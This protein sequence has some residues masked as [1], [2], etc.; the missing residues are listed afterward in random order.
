MTGAMNGLLMLIH[1]YKFDIEDLRKG[2]IISQPSGTH[3]DASYGLDVHDLV[4]MA[5][6]AEDEGYINTAARLLR[7]AHLMVK[8]GDTHLEQDEVKALTKHRKVI[9]AKHNGLL[10]KRKT[11]LSDKDVV[12]IHMLDENLV[13]KKKQP[14]YVTSGKSQKLDWNIMHNH[15]GMFSLM[16]RQLEGCRDFSM[17]KGVEKPQ[18]CY[19]LHHADPFHR[20]APFKLEVASTLPDPHIVVIHGML[21]EEDIRHWVDWATPRLSRSR[22]SQPGGLKNSA[23][24]KG[25]R[26]VRTVY[27]SVNAWKDI[28]VF[29][30]EKFINA[31]TRN[32]YVGEGDYT[33]DNFT[34]LDSRAERLSKRLERAVALNVTNQWS[35]HTSYQV[36]NYGLGGTCEGHLDAYGY[37]EGKYIEPGSGRQ[38]L[39]TT[40]DYMA[41]VMGWLEET[42]LGG[43]TTFFSAGVQVTLRPTRGSIAFWFSQFKDGTLD[44]ATW[45][46]GCPVAIGAKW[47]FNKWIYS[48]NN[49]NRHPCARWPARG[50]QFHE[51]RRSWP[52]SS[53]F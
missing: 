46:G 15:G 13:K 26:K 23:A 32:G 50:R 40:G 14:K 36:T 44:Q 16:E 18:H 29:E 33:P 24:D 1:T 20:L 31:S 30:G 22:N 43:A 49:W 25:S 28:I 10:E 2:R 7:S 27:K 5:L 41:T 21:E 34:V 8:K 42:P 19:R 47:I 35:S 3:F 39:A 53:V 17:S 51:I 52:A 11:F 6:T 38:G 48:F 9:L 37:E 4:I 12:N 45:H